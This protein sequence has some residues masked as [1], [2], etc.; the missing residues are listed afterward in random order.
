MSRA[1][2]RELVATKSM[3][4]RSSPPTHL[5]PPLG[6]RHDGLPP[7][8]VLGG[9]DNALSIARSLGR[10]SIPVH[11]LGCDAEVKHSRYVRPLGVPPDLSITEAI[12]FLI[13]PASDFLRGSVLVAA[14]DSALEGIADG[15]E[16]LQPRFH[17]D[18]SNPTAQKTMLDKLATY[19]AATEAG[20]S[21]PRYWR[22]ESVDSLSPWRPELV[23]PLIVKP[24][25]SHLFQ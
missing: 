16:A 17:L 4:A 2:S 14:S 12:R 10:R 5:E 15:R 22:I 6:L 9:N 13:S 3:N 8:I 18:L 11:A 7:V 20:V 23:Y 19:E 24:K 25:L 21:T 1:V